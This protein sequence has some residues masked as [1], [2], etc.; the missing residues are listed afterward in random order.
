M[1]IR[2]LPVIVAI[3]LICLLTTAAHAECT[4]RDKQALHD[5]GISGYEIDRICGEIK[6]SDKNSS[7]DLVRQKRP[8][9]HGRL[10]E[11]SDICQTEYIWCRVS[12]EAPPG[13]PCLCNSNFGPFYGV[14]IRK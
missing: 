8:D 2:P 13:T 4:L 6:D 14:L 7:E 9:T 10:Q 12:P 5:A 1:K 3:H 11:Y